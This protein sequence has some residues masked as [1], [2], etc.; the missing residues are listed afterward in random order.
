ML[1][2]TILILNMSFL[3]HFRALLNTLNAEDV[4]L[5]FSAM[6]RESIEYVMIVSQNISVEVFYQ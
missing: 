2:L 6:A 5:F 4:S 1:G 3:D